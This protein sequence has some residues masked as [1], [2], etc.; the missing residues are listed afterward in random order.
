MSSDALSGQ[1]FEDLFSE[2]SEQLIVRRL[3]D[4]VSALE[5]IHEVLMSDDEVKAG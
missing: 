1:F 5:I 2:Q 3:L 4:N